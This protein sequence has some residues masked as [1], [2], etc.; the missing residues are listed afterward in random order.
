MADQLCGSAVVEEVL[1]LRNLGFFLGPVLGRPVVYREHLCLVFGGDDSG[2][3]FQEEDAEV[4]FHLMWVV[5]VELDDVLD[6]LLQCDHGEVGPV[7]PFALLVDVVELLADLD[8]LLLVELVELGAEAERVHELAVLLIEHLVDVLLALLGV[9]DVEHALQGLLDLLLLGNLG[10][11]KLLQV[12][13]GRM[14]NVLNQSDLELLLVIH[15][16]EVL[17]EVLRRAFAV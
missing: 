14:K 3:D 17:L 2:E 10:D 15:V 9:L 6:E 11:L 7:D 16:G 4:V 12:L 1:C 13:L 8:E 5:D